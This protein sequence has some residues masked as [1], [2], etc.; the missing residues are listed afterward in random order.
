MIGRLREQ[1]ISPR[2]EYDFSKASPSGV[3]R[4][5]KGSASFSSS[6]TGGASLGEVPGRLSHGGSGPGSLEDTVLIRALVHWQRS[7][8]GLATKKQ[9]LWPCLPPSLGFGSGGARS[10]GSES[11]PGG[12]RRPLCGQRPPFHSQ[13][14][15]LCFGFTILLISVLHTVGTWIGLPTVPSTSSDYT[16][17]RDKARPDPKTDQNQ[18]E[19]QRV[20]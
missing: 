11:G 3:P 4:S 17:V 19:K 20:P 1:Q 13:I 16:A 10:G 6:S 7:G 12:G 15:Q 2:N 18:K 8:S 14:P 5:T 9:D